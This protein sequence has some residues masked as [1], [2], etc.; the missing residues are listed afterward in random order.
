MNKLRTQYRITMDFLAREV[1]IYFWLVVAIFVLMSFFSTFLFQQN[2]EL[3]KTVFS[4]LTDQFQNLT[5]EGEISLW[6][7][8]LNNLK[9]SIMGIAFGFVPFLF[10][11]LIGVISNSAIIGL[12]VSMTD[13]SVYPLWKLLVFGI[14]PHGIFELTAVFICYGLGLMLCWTITKKIIGR[15]KRQNI[16]EL[17]LN[18]LRTLLLVVVPLLAVAAII[19]T[20]VTSYI[21][22]TFL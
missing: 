7:L 21:V 17:L 5:V 16:K 2:S 8:F 18:T 9:A 6:L 13:T 3:T 11:P 10:L 4:S 20:Y 14:L 12:I 1:S 19:E 22:G 15:G